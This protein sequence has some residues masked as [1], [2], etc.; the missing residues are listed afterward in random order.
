MGYGEQIAILCFGLVCAPIKLSSGM[1]AQ[2][3][4]RP[5]GVGRM[6]AGN[7]RGRVREPCIGHEAGH[8]G[9]D[10][11]QRDGEEPLFRGSRYV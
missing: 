7:D 9:A 2:I 5:A 1:L 11:G 4:E 6:E 10:S 8:P 3:A